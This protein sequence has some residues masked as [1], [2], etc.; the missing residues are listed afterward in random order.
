[1]GSNSSISFPDLLAPREGS[2]NATR[3]LTRSLAGQLKPRPRIDARSLFI[4]NYKLLREL[5][6]QHATPGLL[7][8]AFE[9]RRPFDYCCWSR[10]TIDKTRPI[11]I[12]RHP[13]CDL[14]VGRTQHE[15]SLRHLTVLLRAISFDEVR[16]RVLDLRSEAGFS[17][18]QGRSLRAVTAEGSLFVR[19][20]RVVVALLVTGETSW[21][22]KARDAYELIPERVFVEERLRL[23]NGNVPPAAAAWDWD[24]GC[25]THVRARHGVL[26]LATEL[27]SDD[28]E[29]AGTLSLSMADQ[30]I[31]RRVGKRALERGILIGR[32]SRCDLGCTGLTSDQLSR[33]H[34]LIVRD[35]DD[36]LAIDTAS[37]NGTTIEGQ[38]F[39][40]ARLINGARL[41]LGGAL[42]LGWTAQA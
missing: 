13:A 28:D 12:G 39:R 22:D 29:L 26:G 10:A 11:L 16:V 36:V 42:T 20:G 31:I 5:L 18:E 14:M 4:D 41:V 23:I 7:V 17:D 25:C 8:A 24:D 35:G 19:I 3:A 30:Q 38:P 1:M 34:L 37:S 6:Q 40:R 9:E 33:V 27:C 2:T 21:P 32:Y 15:V